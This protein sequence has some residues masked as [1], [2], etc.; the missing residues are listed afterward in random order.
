MK[1]R[2]RQNT[3]EALLIYTVLATPICPSTHTRAT[4]ICTHT[5]ICAHNHA[6]H[7]TFSYATGARNQHPFQD[8]DIRSEVTTLFRRSRHQERGDD[9][10]SKIKTSGARCWHQ[11]PNQT[12]KPKSSTG[13]C[14]VT[15]GLSSVDAFI[16]TPTPVYTYR[17]LHLA[18]QTS[19]HW[20]H[21]GHPAHW[22]RC[23]TAISV[24]MSM[25][26]TKHS[27]ISL[28]ALWIQLLSDNSLS[29]LNYSP[30]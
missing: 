1:R 29:I 26:K 30:H 17:C 12:T 4:H 3:G 5:H 25:P 16:L 20:H 10:L 8:R 22:V 7:T 24:P 19:I 18:R 14:A 27:I 15:S 23:L 11:Q 28:F 6:T 13:T 9:T 2:I 21:P